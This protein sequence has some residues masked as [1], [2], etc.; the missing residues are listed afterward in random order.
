[1]ILDEQDLA[2]PQSESPRQDW[3]ITYS[4]LVSL[5][6]TFFVLLFSMSSTDPSRVESAVSSLTEKF[7]KSAIA[8][9]AGMITSQSGTVILDQVYL[10]SVITTIR[11]RDNI[12]EVKV[13]RSEDGTLMVRLDRD[14]VFLPRTGVLSPDGLTMINGI[15]EA[16][17]RRNS[18]ITLPMAEIRVVG[19]AKEFTGGAGVEENETPV[20]IRQASRIARTLISAQVPSTALTAVL[21]EGVEPGLVLAFYT[22]ASE[23]KNSSPDG[24]PS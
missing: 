13:L 5:M 8:T 3:L 24:D 14:K 7:A 12:G 20:I 21:M 19:D 1:M 11:G 22:I 17:L 6:L 15:A 18:G 9:E 10:D 4:D 23:G 2:L 16:M